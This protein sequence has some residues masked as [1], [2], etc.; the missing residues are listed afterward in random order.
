MIQEPSAELLN[1]A[2]R[3]LL[4][5][6]KI[7]NLSDTAVRIPGLNLRVG[8]DFIIGLI[9]VVGDALMLGASLSLIGLAKSL[10]APKGMLLLMLRNAAIDFFVGMV[11]I[12]GD[13]FDLFFKANHRN[14]KML[15]GW[16]LSE[17]QGDI[18]LATQQ[19]IQEWSDKQS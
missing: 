7:A 19:K 5:A 13:I 18:K 4:L 14:I 16:W 10:G 17:H 15:E 1:K 12:V 3:R 8:L 9:P 2:P 6:Q 11:P